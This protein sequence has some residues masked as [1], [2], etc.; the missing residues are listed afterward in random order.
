MGYVFQCPRC[1]V[2][3]NRQ[4]VAQGLFRE[5]PTCEGRAVTV[6]LLRKLFPEE[7]VNALWESVTLGQGRETVD[8]PFC[9][10]SM[11]EV[12]M[13]YGFGKDEKVTLDVCRK[14][15]TVWFDH[16]E[17][18]KIPAVV[19]VRITKTDPAVVS[20][21]SPRAQAAPKPV[22]AG[23]IV[24]NVIERGVREVP[25]TPWKWVIGFLGLPVECDEDHRGK[26][27]WV[28]WG[29]STILAVVGLLTLQN[30][31]FF[32]ETYGFISAD[33]IRENGIP[34]LLAFFLQGGIFHLLVVLYFLMM[35]GD[36]VEAEIGHFKMIFAIVFSFALGQLLHY[37]AAPDSTHVLIGASATVT[38][39]LTLFVLLDRRV[40]IGLMLRVFFIPKWFSMKATS[41]IIFWILSQVL[42]AH[43]YNKEAMCASSMANLG[44]VIA[45]GVIWLFVIK[46]APAPE[47]NPDYNMDDWRRASRARDDRT[48]DLAASRVFRDPAT[49][50][51]R[52][53][54]RAD[55]HPRSRS[56]TQDDGGSYDL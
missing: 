15:P 41:F 21:E 37:L 47:K 25:H 33:P 12:E 49:N 42:I 39:I 3:L 26:R 29:I 23:V 46:Q 40:H 17:F 11:L 30:V 20:S 53:R 36:N 44:G 6:P 19:P 56:G 28:T 31:S 9:N 27:P 8:C 50:A 32:I 13:R 35:F 45:G 18:E 10:S 16:A 14:C 43:V 22:Q 51:P 24:E 4:F 34:L 55:E 54:E 7:A 48:R 52:G 1:K 38:G 2:P 5:C